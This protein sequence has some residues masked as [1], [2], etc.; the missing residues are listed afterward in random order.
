MVLPLTDKTRNTA[1]AGT[2]RKTE[3]PILILIQSWL[4]QLLRQVRVT[5]QSEE[6]LE[7]AEQEQQGTRKRAAKK[8]QGKKSANKDVVTKK[9]GRARK[10][11]A[12]A[13]A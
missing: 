5:I 8:A 9:R 4:Q 1:N 7:H 3:V 12:H 6:Q 13:A 2:K 11:A 10:N